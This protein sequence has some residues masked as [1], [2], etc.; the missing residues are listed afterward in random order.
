VDD[1]TQIMEMYG[2]DPKT[3]KEFK[4]M[5]IKFTRNK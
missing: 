3:G 5:T 4:T 2:P 1:D